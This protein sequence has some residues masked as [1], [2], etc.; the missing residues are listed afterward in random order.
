[1]QDYLTEGIHICT[2]ESFPE[3]EERAMTIIRK[4]TTMGVA[5]MEQIETQPRA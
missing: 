1:M 3:Y 4:I 5:A 2:R